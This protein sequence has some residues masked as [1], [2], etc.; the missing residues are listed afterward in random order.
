MCRRSGCFLLRQGS[1]SAFV[2]TWYYCWSTFFRRLEA[3]NRSLLMYSR[4]N[5]YLTKKSPS[6]CMFVVAMKF[7]PKKLR[8]CTLL[9]RLPY[10]LLVSLKSTTLCILQLDFGSVSVSLVV[11]SAS[12]FR[13]VSLSEYFTVPS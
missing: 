6:H 5:V 11:C 12:S 2:N 7:P 8:E 4:N 1:W 13:I 10:V 3:F 9:S